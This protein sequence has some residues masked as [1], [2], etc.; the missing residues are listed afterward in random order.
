MLF[1]YA[2]RDH[3]EL[4]ALCHQRSV[5]GPKLAKK[6]SQGQ[7][8]ERPAAAVPS[9]SIQIF[10]EMPTSPKRTI[11]LMMKPSSTVKEVKE[12]VLAK[13]GGIP[14]ARQRLRTRGG[15]PLWHLPNALAGRADAGEVWRWKG[16]DPYLLCHIHVNQGNNIIVCA[17]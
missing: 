1:R 15:K 17:I 13:E 7:V 16:G 5:M 2:E 12:M 11:V 6:S 14:V 9:H 10:V 4:V 8:E 3:E